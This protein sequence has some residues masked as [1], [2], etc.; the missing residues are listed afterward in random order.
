MKCCRP[1]YNDTLTLR[2][3]S[4][5]YNHSEVYFA[6]QKRV[7]FW[8]FALDKVWTLDQAILAVTSC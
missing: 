2:N 4:H 7:Y 6:V 8:N 3:V 5:F 1:W